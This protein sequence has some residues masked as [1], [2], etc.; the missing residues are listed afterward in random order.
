[1]AHYQGAV[2]TSLGTRVY[3]RKGSPLL[4]L[5]VSRDPVG[6]SAG[7]NKAGKASIVAALTSGCI[8]GSHAPQE[9]QAA[10][11]LVQHCCRM[12][13]ALLPHGC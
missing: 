11:P 12:G 2:P 13:A 7:V 6:G 1:M 4:G 10:G 8:K 3:S 9:K 5:R